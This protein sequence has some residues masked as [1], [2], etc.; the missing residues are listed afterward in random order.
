MEHKQD[1]TITFPL[2][3][4]STILDYLGIFCVRFRARIFVSG[5]K[6]D[7][8][9]KWVW[10]LIITS[11]VLATT[12]RPLIS[13]YKFLSAKIEPSAE[14]FDDAARKV[15]TIVSILSGALF[16]LLGL[17]AYF[18]SN[19]NYRIILVLLVGA[20]SGGGGVLLGGALG[21]I[22]Y[23]VLRLGPYVAPALAYA[24]G[25]IAAITFAIRAVFASFSL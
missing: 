17:N 13:Y 10:P 4:F 19:S 1:N 3:C 24:V 15:I 22:T 6:M 5:I 23:G 12:F 14:P 18:S 9:L 25:V 11:A 7:D 21:W 16:F 2:R 8:L 20:L